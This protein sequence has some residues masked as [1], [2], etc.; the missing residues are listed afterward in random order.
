MIRKPR[1]KSPN[2]RWTRDPDKEKYWSKQIEQW[3]ES[4][5]S[6]RSFCKEHGIVETSFYAWRRELIIRARED[7]SPERLKSI[8]NTP[9]KLQDGRG[10][11]VSIRFRQT[12]HR[13]L[14]SLVA[15]PPNNG[16]FVPLSIVPDPA[17]P[18]AP[19]QGLD[20]SVDR[21]IALTTPSGYRISIAH[22]A[23]LD[24]LPKLLHILESNK[25]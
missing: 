15:E 11:S 4:G 22:A 12:D 14:Q 20:P 9:N 5:L 7:H 3:Q 21:G 6:V 2:D 24:L 25:C 16:P 23:V 13:A 10:R 17:P 18:L 19:A 1:K 8:S